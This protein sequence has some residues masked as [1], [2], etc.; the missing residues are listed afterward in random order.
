MGEISYTK[1]AN[2]GV[3]GDIFSQLQ[4]YAYVTDYCSTAVFT[5]DGL[6]EFL[7]DHDLA[8]EDAAILR[9]AIEKI[10]KDTDEICFILEV[11]E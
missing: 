1:T 4:H 7:D 3:N 5:L 6:S 10:D 11:A 9:S 2:I 8:E